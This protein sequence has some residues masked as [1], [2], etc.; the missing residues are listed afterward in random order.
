MRPERPS[1]PY[2]NPP[3]PCGEG[4]GRGGPCCRRGSISIHPPRVGRD[5]APPSITDGTMPFQ[6][7][8]PV[9]GGTVPAPGDLRARY[10]SIHPPRV[11]R[12]LRPA[13]HRAGFNLIS[14]HPPRVGR[15]Q[16]CQNDDKKRADFNPPSPCGEGR[17]VVYRRTA[18]TCRFQSTLP[19]WGGTVV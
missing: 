1:L 4:R 7:T 12:D 2:F 10:I 8:L 9:W 13:T 17:Y 16:R 11:G 14:I 3:S 18:W 19:V 15:D 6:S 5:D